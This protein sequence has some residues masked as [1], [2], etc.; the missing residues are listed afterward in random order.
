MDFQLPKLVAGSEN[1]SNYQE[2]KTATFEE[3]INETLL[4]S[5][6]AEGDLNGLH[7]LSSHLYHSKFFTAHP[8]IIW[9]RWYLPSS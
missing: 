4:G 5:F 3:A 8:K 7:S 1:L 2:E 9:I 6:Q